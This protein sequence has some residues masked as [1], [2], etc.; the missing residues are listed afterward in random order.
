MIDTKKYKE[1]LSVRAETNMSVGQILQ[2]KYN[3][4]VWKVLNVDLDNFEAYIEII[5][6]VP[7]GRTISLDDKDYQISINNNEEV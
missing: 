1:I 3:E 7:V 6:M 4:T 5:G 2:N